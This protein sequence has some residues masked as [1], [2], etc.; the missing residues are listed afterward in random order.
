MSERD[1]GGP[2][3]PEVGTQWNSDR[4][5]FEVNSYGGMTLRDYLAAQALVGYSSN[6]IVMRKALD[7]WCQNGGPR[8]TCVAEWLAGMA[9]ELADAMLE[10]RKAVP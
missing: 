10:E 6:P 2:A 5:Q 3:F 9:Y 8:P 4:E 1:D 7:D